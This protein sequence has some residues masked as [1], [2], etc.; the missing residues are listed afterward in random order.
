[1]WCGRKS[2]INASAVDA[3]AAYKCMSSYYND[4]KFEYTY[5]P[6]WNELALSHYLHLYRPINII[7]FGNTD[8][9]SFQTNA[10]ENVSDEMTVIF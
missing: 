3:P 9:F 8:Q 6:H 5:M 10:F 1:M 2:E 4:I 7:T